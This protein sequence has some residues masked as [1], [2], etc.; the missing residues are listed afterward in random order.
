MYSTIIWHVLSGTKPCLTHL[1]R[2]KPLQKR[3]SALIVTISI[4]HS[5]SAPSSLGTIPLE[6]QH[7]RPGLQQLMPLLGG[8]LL[9][10]V[11]EDLAATASRQTPRW[12]PASQRFEQRRCGCLSLPFGN[13]FLQSYR[14]GGQR[15]VTTFSLGGQVAEGRVLRVGA[16][17]RSG[18]HR[19][20]ASGCRSHRQRPANCRALTGWREAVVGTRPMERKWCAHQ[21]TRRLAHRRCN[22][23]P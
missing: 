10:F 21:P 17:P 19:G 8:L 16:P 12:D 7:H 2:K 11:G 13:R 4:V 1:C 22:S 15:N 3:E 6:V 14:W 23:R 9:G 18:L 20:W 5:H